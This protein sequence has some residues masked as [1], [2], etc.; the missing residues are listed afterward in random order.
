[1]PGPAVIRFSC[2]KCGDMLSAPVACVGR[3][4]KCQSCGQPVT[5]PALVRYTC[6]RCMK[7]LE[8]PTSFAGQKLNCPG[9]N[10]RLQI[11]QPAAPPSINRTVLALEEQAAQIVQGTHSQVLDELDQEVEERRNGSFSWAWALVHSR[12]LRA[13]FD[14]KDRQYQLT[15][16]PEAA[17]FAALWQEVLDARASQFRQV[18]GGAVVVV[19][20]LVIGSWYHLRREHLDVYDVYDLTGEREVA[21]EVAAEQRM[22]Y[23]DEN[24][25]ARKRDWFWGL[26]ERRKA[27][28]A[29][30]AGDAY[31]LWGA[32]DKRLQSAGRHPQRHAAAREFLRTWGT[33][34]T[35]TKV[36]E[37]ERV[38]EDTRA[39]YDAERTTWHEIAALRTDGA[40]ECE[41]KAARLRDYLRQAEALSHDEADAQLR[42]V[43]R[44]WDRYEYDELVQLTKDTAVPSYFKSVEAAARGYLRG[45]R[46]SVLMKEPVGDLIRQVEAIKGTKDYTVVVHRVSIP[47]D[48]DLDGDWRGNPNCSVTVS[49]GS[50]SR[51]TLK[52]KPAERDAHGGFSIVFNQRLESLRL[53]GSES[54]TVTVTVTIHRTLFRD[55]VAS[56]HLKEETLPLLRVTGPVRIIC[57]ADKPVIVHFSCPAA[58]LSGLPPFE[59]H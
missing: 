42:A 32:K 3:S 44:K 40:G 5:V 24:I 34:A 39:A 2:P 46:H 10:Q 6:P 4:T 52:V 36:A 28:D 57:K 35:E 26:R 37:V 33:T 19:V 43:L 27:A 56:H 9:C 38:C 17:R 31:V 29:Q 55:N 15:K 12:S 7:S 58:C 22:T 45:E 8:S 51:Q 48:S 20:L 13:T 11:P 16:G 30:A 14:A 18:L 49:V 47:K 23:Y 1:M 41:R 53:T 54:E 59:A 21:A 50:E 25:A